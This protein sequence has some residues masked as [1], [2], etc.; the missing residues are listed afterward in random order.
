MNNQMTADSSFEKPRRVMLFG[1]RWIALLA[2]LMV[3]QLAILLLV[4]W[5]R[6]PTTATGEA[7]LA[8]FDPAQVQ[9]LTV[10]D[11]NARTIRTTRKDGAWVLPSAGDYAVKEEK[12][13]GLLEKIKGLT[14]DRLVAT[15]SSTLTQLGVAD[16]KFTRR[17]ALEMVD[18]SQ[19]TL[20]VGD[21]PRSRTS[22]VRLNG[23]SNAYLSLGFSTADSATSMADWIDVSYLRIS[24][25][26]VQK[27]SLENSNGLF[28]FYR[29]EQGQWQMSDLAEG[30]TFNPNNLASLL[31][32][33]SSL[34][35][36]EPLGK[37]AK[38]EYGLDAPTA[39]VRLEY[40]DDAGNPKEAELRIGALDSTNSYYAVSS[41]E[42]PYYVYIS[43]YS[44]ERFVTRTRQEFLQQPPTPT[45]QP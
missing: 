17:I 41:T 9:A 14:R 38:P 39:E 29:D 15:K 28:A 12:V 25:A 11:G 4:Y 43:K 8:A 32:T 34:N 1:S 3:L 6:I 7:L 27:M 18:G 13:S 24:E 44:L 19:L 31:T 30:E 45:P 23:E 26:S 36:A 21:G 35:L 10:T 37:E 40:K 33:L 5:P 20:Y 22:H 16:D 2:L 42:S